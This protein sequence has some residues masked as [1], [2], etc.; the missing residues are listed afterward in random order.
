M[1][2]F[3]IP[4]PPYDWHILYLGPIPIRLYAIMIL[5]GIFVGLWLTTKRWVAR[6]GEPETVSDIA[7]WAV[8]FGVIGGRIYHVVSSPAAYFGEN[9]RPID[10]LKIWEG[11]LG[12][13]GAVAFGVL[14]AYIGAKRHKVSLATFVDAAAPGLLIAQ[15]IG[16]LGNWFNHELFGAPTTMPWG[17]VID[18]R[19][20]SIVSEYPVGTLF[21]PTFLYELLW[22]VAGAFL[23]IYLGRRWNLR[24]GRVFWLY[25]MVYT[26]GRFWIE[27]LRIDEAVR[28]GGLRINVWVSI[29]VFVGAA[30]AF[31]W[32][33]RRQR[34]V[35]DAVT[36]EVPQTP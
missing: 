23:I 3:K 4:S 2:P 15:A 7:I 21:H 33:G 24:G 19:A 35:A 5:I 1:M 9:G 16:R 32:Q 30:F 27:T 8:P 10:A 34:L 31:W 14:G 17:L 26:A 12:I 18:P 29:G 6:G 22:N 11:G 20:T 36:E 28:V 25:V 13:W